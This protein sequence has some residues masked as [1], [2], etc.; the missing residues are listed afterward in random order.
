LLSFCQKKGIIPE[1]LAKNIQ[2]FITSNKES[3]NEQK[4]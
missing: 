4:I 1:T 2:A 3:L